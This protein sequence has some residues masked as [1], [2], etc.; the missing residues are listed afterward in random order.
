MA[1]WT[2]MGTGNADLNGKRFGI[3]LDTDKEE[4]TAVGPDVDLFFNSVRKG[5]YHIAGAP[6]LGTELLNGATQV[7]F[8]RNLTGQTSVG[9]SGTGRT[10]KAV[11][12]N[13]T[14]DSK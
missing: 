5:R 3:S 9:D 12:I 14:L 11:T 13:W 2:I 4:W 6:E 1:N 8:F 10:E 7:A